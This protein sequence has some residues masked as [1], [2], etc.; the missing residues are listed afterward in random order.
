M[1]LWIDAACS[2]SRLR[3]FGMSLV[4]RHIRGVRHKAGEII[5]AIVDG[6]PA[7]FEAL[8]AE[9]QAQDVSASSQPGALGQRLAA[10]LREANG[11]LLVAAGDSAIDQRL[12][13]E[14]RKRSGNWLATDENGSVALLRLEPD[15]PLETLAEI[16]DWPGLIAALLYQP[17]INRLRQEDFTAHIAVLRRDLPFWLRRINTEAERAELERFMFKASY[18]G[19]T[20]FFTKYVYPP[21]VW[22][23][24]RPLARMRVHP[25]TVTAVSIVLTFAAVPFFALGW[26]V[27]GLLCAYGMSVLDSVDGK[28]ARLTY[29]DSALGNVLD[30]GLDIVHPPLWY[31]GWAMGLT[32]LGL[33]PYLDQAL[34]EPVFQAA[35]VLVI[36][37]VADRLVLAIY[38]ARFGRGLHAH[39]PIDGI[40]RTVISRRNINLP[41]FTIGLILGLGEEIFYLIVLWQVAT[42]LWHA[43]RTA[44]ILLRGEKPLPA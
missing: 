22:L 31:L 44:W 13:G 8:P 28:L 5:P 23:S 30:H 12:Y 11:P 24:V 35:V 25:N 37:Y 32:G 16:V 3:V 7:T 19:S 38:K 27:L 4:E 39:A 41:L 36:F 34:A 29:S 40:V 2:D 10:A 1:R 15:A 43:A 9:L 18:K 26:W 6:S 20:D 33:W 14:L 21:L 42:V 17:G